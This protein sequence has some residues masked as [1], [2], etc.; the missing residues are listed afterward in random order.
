MTPILFLTD[1]LTAGGAQTVLYNIVENLDRNCYE[2]LVLGL[3]E[4]GSVGDKL[5]GLDVRTECLGM[6]KPYNPFTF[7]TFVPFL[8]KYVRKNKI[9]I[10]HSLLTASGIYGGIVAKCMGVHSILN[11]HAPMAKGRVGYLESFS[12]KCNDILIPGNRITEREL[13]QTLAYKDSRLIYNGIKPE[14]KAEICLLD[15]RTV[16]ITMVANFFAEKDHMTLLRAFEQLTKKHSLHLKFVADGNNEYRDRVVDYIAEKKLDNVELHRARSPDLYAKETDI[17]V[18]A[19][20]AEGLPISVT[21]AMSAGLPVVASDVGAMNEILDH[22]QDGILVPAESVVD[23]V[24]ALDELIGN[25]ELRRQLGENA[26]QKFEAKF[27]M[28]TMTA[29]YDGLYSSLVIPI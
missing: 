26:R 5:R 13:R 16:K 23:L 6:R 22:R 3:F 4:D 21:E 12:R 25:E 29:A 10:I 11:V 2:P 7:A 18:L 28:S 27:T 9:E 14:D 17:F 1:A 19:S 20:H 24:G 15:C 8:A